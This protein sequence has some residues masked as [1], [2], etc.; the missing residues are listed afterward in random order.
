MANMYLVFSVNVTGSQIGVAQ[1]AQRLSFAG[2]VQ[3]K[4]QI[5]QRGVP[6]IL[7]QRGGF[8]PPELVRVDVFRLQQLRRGI[9]CKRIV[10]IEDYR[11]DVLRYCHETPPQAS[12]IS[13]TC[14]VLPSRHRQGTQ[15]SRL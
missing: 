15:V 6:A 11:Y 3:D 13:P 14:A 1:L 2:V 8:L 12:K 4:F 9:V 5:G 7:R 10:K